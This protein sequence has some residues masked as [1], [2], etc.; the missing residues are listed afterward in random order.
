V[1]HIVLG[2]VIF[3][4]AGLIY[5]RSPVLSVSDREILR[6]VT[7]NKAARIMQRVGFLPA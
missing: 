4:V 5:V 2:A 3:V 1:F 6:T 7:P